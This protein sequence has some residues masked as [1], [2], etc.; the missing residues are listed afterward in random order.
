M[1]SKSSSQPFTREDMLQVAIS[2]VKSDGSRENV[3]F[4]SDVALTFEALSGEPGEGSPRAQ[5]L[6]SIYSPDLYYSLPSGG[7]WSKAS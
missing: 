6:S 2:I 7:R 3:D 1:R 4:V 5:S